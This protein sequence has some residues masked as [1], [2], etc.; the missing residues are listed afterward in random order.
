MHG[1][2]ARRKA[3]QQERA[4]AASKEHKT[5][6]AKAAF[7]APSLEC[8]R[9]LNVG[10]FFGMTLAMSESDADQDERSTQDLRQCE[11]FRQEQRR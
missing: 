4:S 11:R 3:S 1:A 8:R 5:P 10:F 6:R 2:E 7:G 9:A